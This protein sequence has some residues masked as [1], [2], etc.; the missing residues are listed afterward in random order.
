MEMTLRGLVFARYPSINAFA[1]D[2]GWGRN[3]ASRIV[4]GVQ[5][6]SKHDMEE[7]I[8]KFRIKSSDVAPIFFG[9]MFTE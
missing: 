5:Q 1:I 4:N 2:M 6:P 9:S 3:K 8:T 7:M